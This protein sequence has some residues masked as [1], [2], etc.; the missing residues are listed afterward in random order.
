M[1]WPAVAAAG[2]TMKLNCEAGADVT[3]TV[4]AAETG[5]EPSIVAAT[6]IG[7]GPA[8]V[9]L[10][11]PVIWPLPSV[12]PAGWVKVTP[13]A[14]VAARVTVWPG[15]GLPFASRTVTVIVA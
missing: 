15:T 6:D 4:A 2:G 10:N 1:G 5:I 12:V 9:E 14:G 13:V 8:L 11:V 7:I 3:V